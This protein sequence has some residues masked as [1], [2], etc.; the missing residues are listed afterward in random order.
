M[1]QYSQMPYQ[2]RCG[3]QLRI[4][5]DRDAR[6]YYIIDGFMLVFALFSHGNH[7]I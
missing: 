3:V 2:H 4:D 7:Y 5:V 1:D 6:N